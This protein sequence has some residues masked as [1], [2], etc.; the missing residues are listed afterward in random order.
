LIHEYN[1]I[2]NTG[3]PIIIVEIDDSTGAVKETRL[4]KHDDDDDDDD[5]NNRDSN[6]L[7]II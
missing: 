6:V 7:L 5:D 3:K 4:G 1:I 2:I